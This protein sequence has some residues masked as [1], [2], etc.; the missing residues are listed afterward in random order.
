VQTAFVDESQIG[1]T[2][3]GR[4]F[5]LTASFA[6][7]ADVDEV[8][9]A[10]RSLLPK[11]A[12]KL[13]WRDATDARRAEIARTVAGLELIHIVI[14][15][16]HTQ[17]EPP[18]RSRR[19]CLEMLLYELG[20]MEVDHAV[21]ESRGP[22]DSLDRHMVAALRAKRVLLRPMRVDHMPGPSEPLLWVPD[23]VN[24]VVGRALDGRAHGLEHQAWIRSTNQ[25]Y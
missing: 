8:R 11:G 1:G 14:V 5:L 16:E 10:M 9:S 3:S 4:P 20:M 21:F 22:S 24:G 18:E 12:K 25:G 7:G 2:G 19:A 13:H 17:N 15:R 6:Y 23:V